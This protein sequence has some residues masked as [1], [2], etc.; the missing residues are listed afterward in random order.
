MTSSK[1]KNQI[2]D[3]DAAWH[4]LH[5][6]L[7][8]DGLLEEQTVVVSYARRYVA[9]RWVAAAFIAVCVSTF[10]L[11]YL[12]HRSGSIPLLALQNGETEGVLV[13]TLEDGSTVYLGKNALL[14]Y[15]SHFGTQKREVSLTGNAVFDIA[16]NPAKPFV[17][18]TQNVQV[19]VLGTAFNLDATSNGQFRL[20]VLRGKVKVSDRK[21]G[22]TV[23]VTAGECVNKQGSRFY[24]TFNQDPLLFSRFTSNLR[25]K[26]EPLVNVIRVINQI[27]DHPVVLEDTS[28]QDEKL[29]VHFYNNNVESMTRVICLALHLQRELRQDTIFLHQ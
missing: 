28:M 27:S 25:F 5:D 4:L 16:R 7:H 6:R 1:H 12:T 2:P 13:K 29:N 9:L 8:R 14:H 23:F 19:E 26:D 3:T 24:K 15:P 17:I 11:I 18:E 21:N 22:E 20:T 10:F